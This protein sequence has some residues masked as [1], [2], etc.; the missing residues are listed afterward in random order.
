[1]TRLPQDDPTTD[2]LVAGEDPTP[3][4]VR[5]GG[6]AEVAPAAAEPAPQ[7]VREVETKL[8]VHGLFKLPELTEAEGVAQVIPQTTRELNA[9]YH[10]TSDLAL[11]RWGVTLRRRTGGPD[12]G[13]HMKL[14]V[15]GA[16]EGVRDELRVSLEEGEVGQVPHALRDVVTAY[17]RGADLVPVVRLRTVRSPYVL[18]DAEGV[19]FAELVDDR[20]SI[21]DGDDV[22]SMFR[23]LEVEALVDG[24]DLSGPVDL[25]LSLGATPSKSSKAASALGPA[26]AEPA[27]IP[28]QERVTPAEPAGDAVTAY[29]RKHAR[30]FLNQDVRV[31]RDL[32]DAVHQMRVAA[33]RLRSG[34]KT[35]GPLVDR[36]WADA[37]REEL[38]WAAG[39][40]GNA[41]D[42]EVLLGRL[43]K[44]A[45]DLGERQA[46]LIR[47]VMDPVL[48]ARL[49]GARDHALAAMRS[50][51]HA[52]LLAMLVDAAV[53]PRLTPLAEQPCSEV[54]PPLV[55]KSWKRLRR[56][57]R[58]LD[59]EGPAESW[60]AARIAAKRARY[61]AGAVIPV[62]G[63]PAETLEDALSEV[64]EVLGEHQDACVAQDVIS[65]IAEQPDVDGATGFALGLLHQHE[66]EE[67]LHNRILFGDI[68]KRTV[69]VYKHTELE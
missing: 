17:V 4:D 53:D 69:R 37:L 16:S 52:D 26:A 8:R 39:E 50:K 42:T 20:V 51:R 32:P 19:A 3:P 1:M 55:D 46:A 63:E 7:E 36:E 6:T 40:L 30:A 11:F 43:D 57:V 64:T 9:V 31:R 21:Y 35:F 44:H 48:R 68:W 56:S 45:D 67:E 24:A 14:P 25:L 65:E 29:L 38:A 28:K 47:G 23:E 10:D 61:A 49:A 41:R 2:E 33:R 60:H 12:E 58:T 5:A 22:V 59:L 66:F 13:W 27:D 54:L 15:D 18:Y 62:F 34:L